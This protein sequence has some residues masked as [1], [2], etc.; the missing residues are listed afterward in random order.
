M[1]TFQKMFVLL[2]FRYFV[3]FSKKK[4]LAM[5]CWL[6]FKKMTIL[7]TFL[8]YGTFGY[9]WKNMAVLFLKNKMW[10]FWLLLKIK[11]G[12]F[13]SFFKKKMS[14]LATFFRKWLFWLVL[15]KYSFFLFLIKPKCGYFGYFW[16]LYYYFVTWV[17]KNICKASFH[18]HV[19]NFSSCIFTPSYL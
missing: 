14:I 5:L 9:F 12:Y 16:K 3:D 18:Q 15:K 7:A 11:Y 10:L 8:N 6:L 13:G 1:T 2:L 17:R 4:I 19:I